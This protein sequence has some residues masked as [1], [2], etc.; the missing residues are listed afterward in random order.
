MR[1]KLLRLAVFVVLLGMMGIVIPVD[2]L[3]PEPIWFPL[4]DEG[5]GDPKDDGIVIDLVHARYA[6]QANVGEKNGKLYYELMAYNPSAAP[7]TITWGMVQADMNGSLLFKGKF[8][9]ITLAWIESYGF[10]GAT[11]SIKHI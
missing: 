5:Y 6:T 2:A 3:P 10:N 1:K 8:D 9:S 4:W 11:F 7:M